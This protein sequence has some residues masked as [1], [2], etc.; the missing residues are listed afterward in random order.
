M[1]L[2]AGVALIGLAPILLAQGLWVRARTPI[3]PEAEGPRA[4]R[5]GHGPPLGL[6]IAGDSSA[7]GVGVAHQDQ[8]LAGQL[9]AALAGRFTLDWRLIAGS[10][11][12][13]ADL[14]A[15]LH[16]A[17][18]QPV[19]AAVVVVGVNDVTARVPVTRWL[20]QQAA[21]ADELRHRWGARR[22]IF[23]AV[24]P[25]RAMTALPR[26]LRGVLGARAAALNAALAQALPPGAAQ[27]HP[28]LPLRP[29]LLA[30]DGF[31]PGAAAYRLWAAALAEAVAP[32]A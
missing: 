26:P 6:L 28:D 11:W 17:E 5:C 19:D 8:A 14:L 23:S 10:G 12:R 2:R 9:A 3:L 20:D 29:D 27:L 15:A 1:R 4:G 13:S 7:A 31:H 18:A 16:E 30:R 22:V 24:P 25:M 32:S 21:L